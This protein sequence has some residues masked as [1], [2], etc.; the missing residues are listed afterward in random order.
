MLGSVVRKEH[1]TGKRLSRL[2]KGTLVWEEEEAKSFMPFE[3]EC[4]KAV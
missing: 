4:A 2:T 3:I 1:S